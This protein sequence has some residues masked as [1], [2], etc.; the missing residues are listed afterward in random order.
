MR[1]LVVAPQPFFEPRGVPFSVRGQICALTALGHQVDLLTYPLGQTLEMA[2]LRIYRVPPLPFIR[3]VRIGLSAVKLWFDVLLFFWAGWLLW[4]RRYDCLCTHEEAG[5]LGMVLSLLFC[6]RHVYYMHSDLAEQIVTAG[7][8]HSRCL[9]A[10]VRS[11]QT[12][13]VRSAA[14]VVTICPEL[15]RT[16]RAM[17]ARGGVHLLE[18]LAVLQED[19]A[20]AEAELERL[21]QEL[22][23][24][25]GPVLLYT[26]TLEIYQGLDLLLESV[27]LVRQRYPTVRYLIVGGRHEQIL[28]L[29]ELGRRLGIE[30][31]LRFVG[32]RPA[33]EMAAYM[34]LADI[35]V[36]PRSRGTNVPLKLATYL[37]S[38]KPVL[39]TAIP[40]HTQLLNAEV[41]LL[42]PPTPQ[43]LAEGTLLLLRDRSHAA[44]LARS[45][46]RYAAERWSRA[47]FLEKNRLIYTKI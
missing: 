44:A 14:A 4:R 27:D 43:G 20:P 24:G 11:I 15:E 42:V 6:C 37:R 10:L 26:G 39:A 22:D 41:A 8:P 7:G 5:A 12:W 13:V 35:L 34:A 23:C 2:G 46:R 29:R 18:N 3:E 38:G 32:Q 17:G 40:A 25:A 1:M 36:S 33:E 47:A 45:A 31:C 16:A 19:H 28:A 21:A 9:L 30:D